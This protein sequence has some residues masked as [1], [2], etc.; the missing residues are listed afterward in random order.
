MNNATRKALPGEINYALVD[1]FTIAHGAVGFTLGAAR[2]P[3]PYAIAIAIGWELVENPLKR[4][5]PGLF[6]S[7]TQDSLQNAT[8]DA[9]AMVAGWLAWR[10]LSSR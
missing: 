6:P 4:N 9:L 8:G 1:R 7:K 2:V 10:S 3:L 5:F